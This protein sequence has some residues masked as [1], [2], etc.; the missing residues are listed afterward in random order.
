MFEI[1]LLTYLSY[2]NG[3]RAKVKGLN[4][5]VWTGLTACAYLAAL[6]LG[7]FVVIAM[8]CRNDINLDQLSSLDYQ[9]RME[10]SRQLEHV[11][12]TNPL[13]STTIIL[14]G[15][16]GYL[17]VRYILER[18]PGKKQEEVPQPDSAE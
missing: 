18:K 3:L 16:G 11:I 12:A 17:L 8:F 9:K 14:F 5:I 10:M 6:I 2:R 1:I 4:T 15:I 13:H 7:M